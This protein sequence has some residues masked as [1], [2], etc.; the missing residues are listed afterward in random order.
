MGRREERQQ[1]IKT[2]SRDTKIAVKM[3]EEDGRENLG[4]VTEKVK[5]ST[6][7]GGKIRSKMLTQEREGL[8]FYLEPEETVKRLRNGSPRRVGFGR[9]SGVHFKY[10]Q[11][12]F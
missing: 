11:I 6:R 1:H 5:P 10:V 9:E 12:L 7:A 2:I 8:A 4:E 3:Q